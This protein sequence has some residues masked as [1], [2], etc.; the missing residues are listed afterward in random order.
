MLPV[1]GSSHDDREPSGRCWC[2]G[3]CRRNRRRIARPTGTARL[4]RSALGARSGA[5]GFATPSTRALADAGRAR[6]G[7]I[8]AW[9]LACVAR[10]AGT[11][12]LSTPC[13]AR[14]GAWG[15]AAGSARAPA[16]AGWDLDCAAAGGIGA[17][18]FGSLAR[19]AGGRAM[20]V[21]AARITAAGPAMLRPRASGSDNMC[22]AFRAAR[23]QP[24]RPAR[25]ALQPRRARSVPAPDG[26]DRPVAR[27]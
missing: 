6:V 25:S 18:A 15:F 27:R 23:S 14:F 1:P 4:T 3:F 21:V 26:T 19:S 24:P 5:W 22:A 2:V 17:W 12:A 10:P 16:G 7:R 13:R 9:A 11:T 20:T 8:G